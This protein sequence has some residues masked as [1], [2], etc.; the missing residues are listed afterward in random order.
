MNLNDLWYVNEN[1]KLV[2]GVILRKGR[3]QPV[4]DSTYI[5]R[6]YGGE[7]RGT[8]LHKFNDPELSDGE[9]CEDV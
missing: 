2:S 1:G 7:G 3:M 4:G 9:A 5:P 8:P 6:E